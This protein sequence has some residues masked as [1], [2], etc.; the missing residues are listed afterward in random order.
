MPER[1]LRDHAIKSGPEGGFDIQDERTEKNRSG[2]KRLTGFRPAV[3]IGE[4]I[5]RDTQRPHAS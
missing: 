1:G 3:D 2:G 4:Q 5:A